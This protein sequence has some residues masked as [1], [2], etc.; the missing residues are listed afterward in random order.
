MRLGRFRLAQVG[1]QETPQPSEVASESQIS[2]ELVVFWWAGRY[3]CMQITPDSGG[4]P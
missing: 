2:R 1:Y 4:E 3:F